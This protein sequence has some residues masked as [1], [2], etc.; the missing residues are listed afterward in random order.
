LDNPD[1]CAPTCTASDEC[2][3]GMTCTHEGVCVDCLVNPSLCVVP[4]AGPPADV[5]L[6]LDAMTLDRTTE[7]TDAGASVVDAS[8]VDSGTVEP[9]QGGGC[10]CSGSGWVGLWYVLPFTLLRRRRVG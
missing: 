5:G 4:D 3:S 8:A 10:S 6:D 9:S 7:L 2:P 1:V